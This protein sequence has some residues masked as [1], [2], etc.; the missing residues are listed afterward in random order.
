HGRLGRRTRR[1]A[2]RRART[3]CLAVVGRGDGAADLRP[4]L[5]RAFRARFLRR[6]CGD[7]LARR[8]AAAGHRGGGVRRRRGDAMTR[9]V[10]LAGALLAVAGMGGTV[11]ARAVGESALAA[12][13]PLRGTLVALPLLAAGFATLHRLAVARGARPIGL[14]VRRVESALLLLLA[15]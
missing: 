5:P 1:S 4:A 13:D 15:I 2:R 12:A 14:A 10:R 11:L 8:R 9:D 7:D 6:A 3:A